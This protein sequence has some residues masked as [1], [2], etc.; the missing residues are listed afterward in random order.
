MA[1]AP[2][3]PI[4]FE[5]SDKLSALITVS[6]DLPRL[7]TK[8]TTNAEKQCK[9][10]ESDT[11]TKTNANP[12]PEEAK[13]TKDLSKLMLVEANISV[14]IDVSADLTLPLLPAPF[15]AAGTTAKIFSTE[16]PLMTSCVKPVNGK[17]KI[18]EMAPVAT[19]KAD[20]A[21]ITT[22]VAAS[23]TASVTPEATSTCTKHG[24]EKSCTCATATTTVYAL[25]PTG[26][27]G[28]EPPK[29]TN[30]PLQMTPYYP[31]SQPPMTSTP[32]TSS[33][34][35]RITISPAPESTPQSIIII[36]GLKPCNSS[37]IISQ[38]GPSSS[39]T[40]NSS[41][42]GYYH[43]S[44]PSTLQSTIGTVDIPPVSSNTTQTISS[45]PSTTT[46]LP[47]TTSPPNVAESKGF[48]APPSS[49]RASTTLSQFTGAAVPRAT[50]EGMG[51]GWREVGWQVVVVG[52]S[53]GVGVVGMLMV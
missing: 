39:I 2:T 16:M 31:I 52:V 5:F 13:T 18:T 17:L 48:L 15:D 53:L 33:E 27:H 1:F 46:S 26:G 42:N 11:K 50:V 4:G 45:P 19:I 24:D 35:I 34:T 6:L 10:L 49:A 28:G 20:Q 3:I 44:A 14:A 30:P 32:C 12:E 40:F 38:H 51:L 37:T 7:D 36:P 23:V 21:E 22:E 43:P 9:A 41:D 25:P 8:L 29:E 47:G